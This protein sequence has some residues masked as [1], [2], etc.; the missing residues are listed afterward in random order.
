MGMMGAIVS[1][2]NTRPPTPP[3][4]AF[5]LGNFFATAK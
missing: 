2:T 5:D 1:M 3:A 4:Q